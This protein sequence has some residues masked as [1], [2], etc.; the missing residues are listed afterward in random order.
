VRAS[1]SLLFRSAVVVTETDGRKPADDIFLFRCGTVDSAY[2]RRNTFL[3]YIAAWLFCTNPIQGPMHY[4]LL[5]AFL[6][7]RCCRPA[8]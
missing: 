3:L 8:S 5:A 6:S 1:G 4:G 2:I 7:F